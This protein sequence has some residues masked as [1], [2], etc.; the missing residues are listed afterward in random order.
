MCVR[1]PSA[2]RVLQFALFIV[3][4]YVLHRLAIRVIHRLQV[5]LSLGTFFFIPNS[6][7]VEAPTGIKT[8]KPTPF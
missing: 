2:Q 1:N 6:A 3:A 8:V 7:V 5:Y 4:S